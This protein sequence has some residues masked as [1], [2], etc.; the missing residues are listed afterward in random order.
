MA[1]GPG[2]K[3]KIQIDSDWKA[4]A[5]REKERLAEE[6]EHVGETGPIPAPTIQELIQMILMQALIGINGMQT[7]DGRTLRPDLEVAKHHI[8][9]LAL[10]AEK[11]KGNLTDEE[12]QLMD[13]ALYEVRMQFVR[14][15]NA[16]AGAGGEGGAAQ[17]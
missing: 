14:A 16:A 15:V 3:P 13:A 4:E 2:D 10:I 7:P 5:Q 1:D 17:A 8:D 12:Q 9:L 6:T 11:T